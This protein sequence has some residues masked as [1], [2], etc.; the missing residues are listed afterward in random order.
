MNTVFNAKAQSTQRKLL[1]KT[2][3]KHLHM[4]SPRKPGSGSLILERLNNLLRS[5]FIMSNVLLTFIVARVWMTSLI[6]MSLVVF[7][8]LAP[9]R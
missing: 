3:R 6:G 5:Y 8:F 4:S 2:A 7:A 1:S 9:L